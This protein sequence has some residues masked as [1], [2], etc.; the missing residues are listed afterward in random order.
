MELTAT[1]NP[2]TLTVTAT[3][4]ANVSIPFVPSPAGI[5]A[6]VT[7]EILVEPD[8]VAIAAVLA[9]P[10]AERPQPVTAIHR[11]N[12]TMP[13]PA[14]LL[15]RG[16]KPYSDQFVP[17][18]INQDPYGTIRVTINGI[19]MTYFR[20]T[21][22]TLTRCVET[23]PFGWASA[24]LYFPNITPYETSANYLV[25][26]GLN[27]EVTLLNLNGDVT[28]T[29]FE[30]FIIEREGI[31]EEAGKVGTKL[32]CMGAL[33]QADFTLAMKRLIVEPE[34]IARRIFGRLESVPG[35]RYQNVP[36]DSVITGIMDTTS[37]NWQPILT[38]YIQELLSTATTDTG[39]QWTLTCGPNRTVILKLKDTTTVNHTVTLGTPGI[40]V[41]FHKDES[42]KT[43]TIYGHGVDAD[44]NA[45]ANLRFPY[46]AINQ[47]DHDFPYT[48]LNATLHL[49]TKDSD[50][51]TGHGV[52]VLQKRLQRMG[53]LKIKR[54][55][56]GTIGSGTV[57]AITGAQRQA[58]IPA[59]GIVDAQ[60]WTAIFQQGNT[61]EEAFYQ[62]FATVLETEQ[63]LYNGLGQKTGPNPDWNPNL[64]R[65]ERYRTFTDGFTKDE[66]SRSAFAEIVRDKDAAWTGTI[67]M[68]VD[69]ESTIR[70]QHHAGHN[71]LVKGWEGTN[72]LLHI[73][74]VTRDENGN[75]TMQV[76][77]KARDMLTLDE[78][79]KRNN[80]NTGPV[81]RKLGVGKRSDTIGNS[82]VIDSELRGWFDDVACSAGEWIVLRVPVGNE[83]TIEGMEFQ[84]YTTDRT[85]TQPTRFCAAFF[86]GPITP[87]E[88]RDLCEF[89]LLLQTGDVSPWEFDDWTINQLEYKGFL[90]AVGGFEQSAG[91]YP[92]KESTASPKT[93]AHYDHGL[94][95]GFVSD[96][97]IWLYIGI[98]VE[99]DCLMD[100]RIIMGPQS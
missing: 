30:G 87:S 55:N 79:E 43:T 73:A 91:Y 33:Y 58:G 28:E 46:A 53:L 76:D 85:T 37:G 20:G 21:P 83:G 80:E 19:D 38:G 50:T 72:L 31:A 70:Y 41:T 78:I 66:A 36:R 39:E 68:R 59:D 75:I 74:S 93:G 98:W 10:M 63:Y 44:N 7:G 25:A 9:D 57:N 64:L 42:Q 2:I 92:G 99:D 90:D 65:I 29:L 81:R 71:I 17:T 52:T 49:G 45:F 56:M 48:D 69:A 3:G 14:T 8:P 18:D 95:L 47:Q 77:T 86:Q 6:A 100:G 94:S 62:P 27:I 34:D 54:Q 24:E 89:P 15:G 4:F 22:C 60:T 16:G 12:I 96:D 23:E 32:T 13:N 40:S 11:V 26:P 61:L 88:L 97:N 84:A 51:D 35:Y 67:K 1:L 5:V 82:P